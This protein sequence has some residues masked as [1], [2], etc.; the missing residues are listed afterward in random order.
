MISQAS[1]KGGEETAQSHLVSH[2]ALRQLLAASM[3]P[4]PRRP[5]RTDTRLIDLFQWA[6][7]PDTT[8]LSDE[9]AAATLWKPE[10]IVKLIAAKHFDLNRP[11]AF[12]NEINLV[13]LRQATIVA[14]KIGVDIDRLFDWAKPGSKFWDCH[15]IAEDIRKAIRAR[16]DE[17]VWEQVVK[18]LNDQLREH[19]KQALIAF[20][21]V[22]QDLI[23]WGVGTPARDTTDGSLL[24]SKLH[25]FASTRNAPYFFFYRYF[26]VHEKNWYPWEKVQ[27]DIPSYDVERGGI[28][29]N[30]GSYLIPVAWNNRLLIFFP[31]F[32]KKTIPSTASANK[33]FDDLRADKVDDHGAKEFWEI[34]MGWSEYRNGKWTQKQQSATGIYDNALT[35][36][37]Y[38][39]FVPRVITDTGI[40]ID[41]YLNLL[42]GG[43]RDDSLGSFHFEGSQIRAD[44]AAFVTADPTTP[45]ES[46]FQYFSQGPG[47]PTIYSLQATNTGP[48]SLFGEQPLFNTYDS[49]TTV[50]YNKIESLNVPSG[51]TAELDFYHPFVHDLL[52]QMATGEL[53]ALFRFYRDYFKKWYFDPNK[54]ADV[55]GSYLGDDGATVSFHELKR[56]YSLYNWEAT[57]HAPMLLVDR[58]LKANQFEQ[59]L[60]MCHYILNPFAY[61]TDAK[62]FWKFPPFWFINAENVLE[63]LFLS[64]KPGKPD[65]TINEWRDKPFRPHVVARGRPAAYMKWVAMT[66]IKIHIEWGDYLFRQDTIETINQ[67]TQLYVLAAHFCGPC[68]QKIPKRGKVLP[69][70]Y[71]SLLDKWNAFGNAMVE[72]EVALPFSNQTPFPIG[73]SNGVVGLP[74]VFG[75]ATTLYFCIPDNP[76][77]TAL[78][79][80]IDDRLFK[81]RHC[82][83]IAGVF[84]QLPL[85]DPPIDP[86][87][88][89]Q[90]AAQ[91]LSIASVLND[92]NSP[93]PNYRFYFLLQKALEVCNELKALGAAFLSAKEKGD[94]EALSRLRATHESA[95]QNL[96]ME[97]RKQQVDEAQK[98]LDALQQSRK[99]PVDRM[100]YFLKLIDV[101]ENKVPSDNADFEAVQNEIEKPI[102]DSGLK[103]ISFEKEEIDKAARVADRQVDIGRI[104]SIAGILHAIP[105]IGVYI[106]PIG[107][108]PKAEFGGSHLGN[109][110][111]G[112]ARWMQADTNQL[113]YEGTNAGRKAGFLRQL[114]DRV[115]QANTAG[116]EIKNID[117]Q[118]LTQN[119]RINIANQEITNQQKQIDNAKEVE[120]FLRNKYTNQELYAWMESQVRTL[121]YQAY[122]LAYDLAKKAEK[123]FRFERGLQE[124]NFIQFGYWDPAYD[125]LF[126][127]E[128][129]YIGLK[130]LEAAYQEKRGYDFEVVKNISLQQLNPL[131]LIKL[132]ETGRC[133]FAL[134]EVLFDMGYPGQY[135]RRIKTVALTFA[136]VVGPP[137][138]VNCVLRLLEHKFRTSA[139]AGK[140]D[141]PEHT[142]ETDER[143][144]T[145]N[146]PIASIAVSTGQNDSGVSSS[147]SAM[148]VT[149][150]SKAPAPSANGGSSYR[151][152]SASSTMTR[153][154]M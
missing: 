73:V 110:M 109:A 107:C 9:I 38:F 100:K 90:A 71:N 101:N 32:M 23:I 64:L 55:Y 135:M 114:Q 39:E 7:K 40:V 91:G 27:V 31:Q 68:G 133:E 79:D 53:E 121:Y 131:A 139:I 21:L 11:E 96:V 77:L 127:G 102:E 81:I 142:D 36:L 54:A 59:A 63:T 149:F 43:G 3:M 97:V 108:G 113:S 37:Q 124:S 146:V 13:K 12:R 154:R 103:L 118:M 98:S 82:E 75:F 5:P 41:C 4:H 145:V 1:P 116:Y 57:F 104:E 61:E 92:L 52:G 143:F 122:T 137:T 94:G 42:T 66:Y 18:P 126:A 151:K 33:K 84:R 67:A 147:I 112:V 123:G 150:R 15:Q 62:S 88:L 129:M 24:F 80:T 30:H 130:Q 87:L 26:Q 132:R 111:Q 148:N 76:E 99:G 95:V 58:L 85:F 70:T 35:E 10:N 141:Y 117:K 49:H 69:E 153:S 144:S 14:D 51:E 44:A 119:I 17:D 74:N 65:S 45:S 50:K 56:A 78:R 128:R 25:V 22:Q 60:N 86:A 72:L 29:V 138:S 125:G 19:Q 6:I 34:K 106:A 28:I 120:E 136:C 20:L 83:N 93:M 16:F 105:A 89:V 46:E 8:P 115:Q 152:R 2:G 48:L 140:N 134:P 47:A